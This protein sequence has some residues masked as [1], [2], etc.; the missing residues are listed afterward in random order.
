[1]E[2]SSN[3]PARYLAD[4]ERIKSAF[5]A[6]RKL[7]ESN[8]GVDV[9]VELA[10]LLEPVFEEQTRWIGSDP[11]R[12][13]GAWCLVANIVRDERKGPS[14]EESSGHYGTKAFS[15]G[16][17][18]YPAVNYSGLDAVWAVVGQNRV[19][20]RNTQAIVAS[21]VLENFRPQFVRS[22]SILE[23]LAFIGWGIDKN[24]TSA[25]GKGLNYNAGFRTL[26]ASKDQLKKE[27]PY[28]L[29]DY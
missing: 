5:A 21:W 24:N 6:L 25:A 16:A 2:N 15:P 11:P 12:Q 27:F 28:L 9:S 22:I 4:R 7:Q 26:A 1:M 8:P 14:G 23:R 10:R 3:R 13:F 19:S 20:K 18:V 17:K 29:K